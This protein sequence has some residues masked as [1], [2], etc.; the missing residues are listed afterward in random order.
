MRP[1]SEKVSFWRCFV[2][3]GRGVGMAFRSERNLRIH[4][5]CFLVAVVLGFVVH[6]SMLEWI[7]LVLCAAFVIGSEVMNTAI[8]VLADTLHPDSHPGIGKAKDLAAGAVLIAAVAAG[9]VGAILFL[10]KLW[11]LFVK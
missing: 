8:E 5:V 2:D 9:V 10:P 7:G 3:A 1:N 4:L 6:L 11:E